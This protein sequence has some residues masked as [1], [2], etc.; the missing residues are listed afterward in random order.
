MQAIDVAA[1]LV[2]RAGQLL[3][4]QR[5]SQDHLGG[6]WEFPGGKRELNESFEACLKRE[7]Q[8]ELDI[9]VKVHELVASVIHPYP[10]KTVQLQ[11]YRCTLIQGTPKPI[12]C[13]NLAWVTASGLNQYE[14]PPADAQLLSKLT[15]HPTW[16]NQTTADSH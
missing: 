12:G 13:Q 8:E 10:V 16:W 2:F 5:R 11:F 6:L 14:F 1:G 3:I 4:T 15:G 9:I 7:L